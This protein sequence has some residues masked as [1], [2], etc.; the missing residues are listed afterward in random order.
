MRFHTIF[1]SLFSISF[2]S[3]SPT[4]FA[5]DARFQ[6]LI[7]VVSQYV[8]N[9]GAV[10]LDSAAS[11]MSIAMKLYA[12][13]AG[14]KEDEIDIVLLE[15]KA[16][17]KIP[18][19]QNILDELDNRSRSARADNSTLMFYFSGHGSRYESRMVLLGSGASRIDNRA[20]Q[21]KLDD[22]LETIASS[23]AGKKFVFVDACQTGVGQNTLAA[24]QTLLGNESEHQIKPQRG[25]AVFFSSD[26]NEYSYV[27][28][29]AKMGYYT[30]HLVSAL[31]NP[32]A[33][34]SSPALKTWIHTA[35]QLQKY[36]SS[37]V[38]V[39]V[40]NSDKLSKRFQNPRLITDSKQGD[41][42]LYDSMPQRKETRKIQGLVLKKA[43]EK[44]VVLKAELV[45]E[46][47]LLHDASLPSDRPF[48]Y[49]S[50]LKGAC[51]I[52]EVF[53]GK[54]LTWDDVGIVE[55]CMN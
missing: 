28:P 9:L 25:M 10:S 8:G 49:E 37:L 36:L 7:A 34:L 19:A 20:Y 24:H 51:L 16:N 23:G 17:S 33:G 12:I 38:P 48:N 50:D 35:T 42:A 52:R 11:E 32:G 1:V 21:V 53:A 22:V 46:I 39:E 31:K 55:S 3:L 2:F 6:G 13:R 29:Q 14:Y 15:D 41:L 4:A 45:E 27:D 44:G 30:K 18:N 26:K 5:G 47:E 43:G 40:E 54:L